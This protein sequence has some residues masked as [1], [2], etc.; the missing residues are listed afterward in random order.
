MEPSRAERVESAAEESDVALQWDP[1]DD[2]LD[3][4]E[5]L[6]ASGVVAGQVGRHRNALAEH[7]PAPQFRPAGQMGAYSAQDISN[8]LLGYFAYPLSHYSPGVLVSAGS[9]R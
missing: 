4:Y 5:G 1:D 8:I 7:T 9:L 6:D 2:L 3:G